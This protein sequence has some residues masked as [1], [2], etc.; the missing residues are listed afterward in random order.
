MGLFGKKDL[1]KFKASEIISEEDCKKIL[2]T[3]K[4]GSYKTAYN[5][6]AETLCDFAKSPDKEYDEKELAKVV[7][8]AGCFTKIE[9]DLAPI[10]NEG[11]KKF[12]ELKKQK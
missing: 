7:Y 1:P 4:P 11:I 6:M 8:S 2:A 3:V 12:K 10:L 9:P 5:P